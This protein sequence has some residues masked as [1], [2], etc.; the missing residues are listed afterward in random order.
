MTVDELIVNLQ[1]QSH[2]GRG[3]YEVLLDTGGPLEAPACKGIDHHDHDPKVVWL[4]ATE[5]P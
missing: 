1:V 5:M 2:C 4:G 3:D